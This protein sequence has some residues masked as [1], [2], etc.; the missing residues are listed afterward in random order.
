MTPRAGTATVPP[1]G[2]PDA[3]G[4]GPAES[5]HKPPLRPLEVTCT[6]RALLWG[7]LQP[8]FPDLPPAMW[9]RKNHLS[10]KL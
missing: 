6:Q 7:R 8:G 1:G 3:A 5:S 9:K 2:K 10:P 4:R